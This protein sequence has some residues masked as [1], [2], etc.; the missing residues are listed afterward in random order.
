MR[1]RTIRN[2][3]DTH[4]HDHKKNLLFDRS[5]SLP[6]IPAT[7]KVLALR[8]LVD[9]NENSLETVALMIPESDVGNFAQAHG[10]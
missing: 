7:G 5:M 1:N 8:N 9:L 2:S 3:I 4:A 10:V 6:D